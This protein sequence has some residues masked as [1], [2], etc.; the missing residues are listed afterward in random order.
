MLHGRAGYADHDRE[1]ASICGWS[2]AAVVVPDIELDIA[3]PVIP[4]LATAG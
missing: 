2:T 1:V 4:Q 3:E